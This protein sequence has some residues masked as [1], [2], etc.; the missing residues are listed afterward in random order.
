[1]TFFALA[2]PAPIRRLLRALPTEGVAVVTIG[3]LVLA[4]IVSTDLGAAPQ[5]ALA[6]PAPPSVL[7]TVGTPGQVQGSSA[8]TP[9]ATPPRSISGLISR[10]DAISKAPLRAG[11]TSTRIEAKLVVPSDL[12][13]V[14]HGISGVG[15]ADYVWAVASW[16]QFATRGFGTRL[17]TGSQ[18]Q[19]PPP[20]DGWRFILINAR[21]GDAYLGGGSVAEQAWWTG[22][23]DRSIDVIR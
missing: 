16:G 21:T 17:G 6:S 12:A 15:D 8:P 13:R 22:L 23:L 4:L 1:M 19:Q 3:V 2:R 18:Q 9:P 10:E 7:P 20:P 11:D 14:G 5:N